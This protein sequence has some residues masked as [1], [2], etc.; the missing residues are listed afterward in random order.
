MSTLSQIPNLRLLALPSTHSGEDWLE[1]VQRIDLKIQDLDLELESETVFII[2][3]Q[4][5]YVGRPIIGPKKD[6]DAPFKLIDLESRPVKSQRPNSDTWD[7]LFKEIEQFKNSELTLVSI[8][9]RLK[10]DLKIEI[11]IINFQ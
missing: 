9:R 11:E 10:P 6:P 4:H 5:C 1:L 2:F 3:D 7:I 8:K